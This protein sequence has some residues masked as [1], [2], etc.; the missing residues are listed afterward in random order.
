[1]TLALLWCWQELLDPLLACSGVPKLAWTRMGTRAGSGPSSVLS[2]RAGFLPQ[3]ALHFCL[4]SQ[5]GNPHVDGLTHGYSIGLKL[6]VTY[7]TVFAK[8]LIGSTPQK[9]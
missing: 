2:G 4:R 7:F 8:T 1:M 5:S 6:L 9:P 3:A